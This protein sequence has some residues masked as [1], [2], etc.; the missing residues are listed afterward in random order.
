MAVTL[1]LPFPLHDQPGGVLIRGG[2]NVQYQFVVYDG[3]CCVGACLHSPGLAH[4][5][6]RG[7]FL[8]W[9]RSKKVCPLIDMAVPHV[10]I[11]RVHPGP[12]SRLSWCLETDF[13]GSGGYGDTP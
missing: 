2:R 9:P 11:R 12:L 1:V 5:P 3:G 13:A 10:H 6:R 4:D 7:L 8:L